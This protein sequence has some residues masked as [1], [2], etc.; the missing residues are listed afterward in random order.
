MFISG[1]ARKYVQWS[2]WRKAVKREELNGMVLNAGLMD[3]SCCNY[4]Y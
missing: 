1:F 3:K 2:S 4:S